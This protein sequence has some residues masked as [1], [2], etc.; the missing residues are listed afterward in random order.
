MTE[1]LQPEPLSEPSGLAALRKVI[2]EGGFPRGLGRTLGV[3]LIAV[4]NGRVELGGAPTEDHYNPLGS[5]HGGYVAAMLDGAIALAVYSTL[6]HDALYATIDLKVAYLRALTADS[7]PVRA[8]GSIIQAGRR[9]I[10]GEGRLIDRE[11][12]LC[13]HATATCQLRGP[14]AS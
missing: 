8:E 13:A 5:V 2:L 4:D 6:P 7:G 14:R 1:D 9:M 11:R 3:R 10:L 12:R